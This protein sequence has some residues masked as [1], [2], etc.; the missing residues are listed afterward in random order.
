M[1]EII[2]TYFNLYICNE[3]YDKR[4]K[5]LIMDYIM[6]NEN[7]LLNSIVKKNY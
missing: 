1:L 4:I 3:L 2:R 6:I 7:K 5:E